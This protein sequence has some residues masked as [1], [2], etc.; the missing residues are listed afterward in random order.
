MSLSHE[1][2]ESVQRVVDASAETGEHLRNGAADFFRG[3]PNLLAETL[4]KALDFPDSP[5]AA[6]CN[7]LQQ[8]FT[9]CDAEENLTRSDPMH[10]EE[11]A[12]LLKSF[13][14]VVE[15]ALD[16]IREIRQAIKATCETVD[17][18][19]IPPEPQSAYIQSGDA[20]EWIMALRCGLREVRNALPSFC[21]QVRQLRR[22]AISA[23][24]L[25]QHLSRCSRHWNDISEVEKRRL[26]DHVRR[27]IR[28]RAEHS[29]FSELMGRLP[30]TIREDPSVKEFQ[31]DWLRQWGKER[32]MLLQEAEEI[33]LG[34][35]SQA[36]NDAYSLV[37]AEPRA[38]EKERA[39]RQSISPQLSFEE[40]YQKARLRIN[41][42]L[43]VPQEQY[44][45]QL[46]QYRSTALRRPRLTQSIVTGSVRRLRT[47][48]Q[49]N[50]SMMSGTKAEAPPESTFP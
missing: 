35:A 25:E 30:R 39:V 23:V 46:Q 1:L 13:E 19:P 32:T 42:M 50:S 17:F 38:E 10:F 49:R 15:E 28:C 43:R 44:L 12:I 26:A 40:L 48:P 33:A 3:K 4:Q 22:T 37:T 36:S 16:G 14:A 21:R 41:S 18:D 34:A 20:T 5:M 29:V 6:A 8:L 11:S 7:I 47:P 2:L 9:V 24:E 27:E 45:R 31:Q